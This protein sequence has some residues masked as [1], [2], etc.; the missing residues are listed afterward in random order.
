VRCVEAANVIC[1]MRGVPSTGLRL[2]A[3]P[4]VALSGLKLTG[5]AMRA[6]ATDTEREAGRFESLL[7][8]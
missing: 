7:E 5:P 1:T 6:L 2:V 4:G 8:I 3:L